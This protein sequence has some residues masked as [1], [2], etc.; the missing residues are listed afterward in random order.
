MSWATFRAMFSKTHLD[1]LIGVRHAVLCSR[2]NAIRR[3][4]YFECRISLVGRNF[5]DLLAR[6]NTGLIVVK[7]AYA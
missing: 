6:L 2:Q 4:T 5:A 1:N 3:R 7:F